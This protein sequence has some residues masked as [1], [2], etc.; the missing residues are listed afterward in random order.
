MATR[1]LSVLSDPT[2]LADIR[3]YGKFDSAGCYQCG[4]CTVSCELVSDSASFPRKSIRYALLGLR[5][6]L[7]GSL[8]PWIC[9]DCGDCSIMCPR[10][11]EPRISM[12]TLRRFLTA[13]YDWTGIAS[14]LLTSRAWYLGSL[15]F[16]G[17]LVVLLILCYHLWYVGLAF[18]QLATPLGLEHMFP[19]MTYYTLT[20]ILLPL[21]LLLSRVFRI[22]RFTMTGE[23]HRKIPFS[24]YV[25]EAWVYLRESVA[26]SL[27]HKC[28][29][30]RR[31]LG[32]WML[33]L[34][35]TVMLA[36][37]VFGLRWFQTD[38]IYPFYHPQRLVG[39]LASGLILY[40][41]GGILWGRIRAKRE[42]YKET[43]FQDLVLPV[44]LLFT[45]LSGLVAHISRYAGFALT[46]HF[47]YAVH[48]IIA[49]PMLVVEMAFGKW[50]H[51]IYRPLAV[52]FQAVKDRA[53]RQAPAQ[54]GVGYAA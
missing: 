25:R 26:T 32:H 20:V 39:Y 48:V 33:A 12:A 22:W 1:M 43:R 53:E 52:Y 47:A 4:T 41:I 5:T 6:P 38:N 46:G 17:T 37:K 10:Q 8:E 24:A 54:E 35:T 34:G 42:I 45:V 3:Q 21:L 30:H 7:V 40:G 18:S 9:E 50:A 19:L 31:W 16:V 27:L 51:M 36:I 23:G 14:R 15:A 44:L 28:P 49:T 29:E 2:L 13:Q 11:A